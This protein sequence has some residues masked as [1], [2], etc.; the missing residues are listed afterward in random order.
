VRLRVWLPALGDFEAGSSLHFEV[1]DG[2]RRI[3]RRGDA[4]VGALPRG[5]D[6]EAV[7]DAA[8]VL[9]LEARLPKL[10]GAR[11]A[12]ALPGL[13]EERVAADIDRCHVVASAADGDGH[14]LVAVV[15]RGLL[16]RALEILQRAGQ[17]VVQATPQPLAL[18][19]TVGNWRARVRDGHGSVRTGARTGASFGEGAPPL[20]LKLLL[21]QTARRPAAIEVDG[22][23]DPESWSEGLGVEVKA[24]TPDPVAPPMVLDLLQYEFAGSLVPWQAW[25]GTRALGATLL[26]V[27]V[28]GLNVH[29][30]LLHAQAQA[31][32]ADMVNIVKEVNPQVPVVLDP[33]AQMRRY[34]SDLRAG[35]GTDTDGFL[36]L[37]RGVASLAPPDSVQ[38]MQYRGGHLS[39]RLRTLPAEGD[40]QR[41]VL[42]ERA[43]AAGLSV[44]VA[45][46]TL[47][48]SR[49][50]GP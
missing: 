16:R 25:R 41:K 38:G 46:D 6:C 34:L 44:S 35:A 8:D 17:R 1:L 3:Q 12:S 43:A 21:A 47:Q 10:S 11:L 22:P 20:E 31:L 48:V 27:G 40:A 9:L 24:A 29:A 42:L 33:V 18:A 19:M 13:V 5:M 28:A 7:L 23:F 36:A 2:Q 49:K 26:L 45:G 4:V 14:A 50:A 30:W 39:V 15:D 32:R 37:A